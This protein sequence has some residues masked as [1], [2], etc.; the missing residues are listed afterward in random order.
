MTRPR[1]SVVA[2][3]RIDRIVGRRNMWTRGSARLLVWV[4]T[5]LGATAWQM[6][7]EVVER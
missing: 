1:W 4:A 3:D 6:R 7:F 5:K 2:V